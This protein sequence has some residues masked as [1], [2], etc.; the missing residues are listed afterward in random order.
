VWLLLDTHALV[1]RLADDS[2]LAATARDTI[3]RH[4]AY[5]SVSAASAWEIATKGASASSRGRLSLPATSAASSSEAGFQPLAVTV[6]YGQRTGALPGPINDP[7][8]RVL[9]AQAMLEDLHLVSI[10]R[11]FDAYGVKRLW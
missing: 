6:E 5:V 10:E 7:F 4:R 11:A 2:R 1:W 3:E 9:P 8:A